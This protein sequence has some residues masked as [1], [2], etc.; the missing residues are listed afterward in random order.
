LLRALRIADSRENFMNTRLVLASALFVACGSAFAAPSATDTD[1]V[2][3]A[4]QAGI[5]EIAAGH[6]AEKQGQ[7]AGTK[8]FGKRMVADH[9]KAAD[10]LKRAAEKSGA[11]MPTTTSEAQKQAGEKLAGLRGDAFDKAYAE[12][13]VKD[14]EEAV[15]LFEKESTSGSDSDLKAFA[16]MTLPTL[17]EH[18]KMARALP[19][20]GAK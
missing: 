15:A 19:G 9:T 17:Q 10:G 8:A 2:T 16:G 1:F 7:S 18:L 3:K 20:G 14:H 11:K 5:A 6:M 13:M 4:G 12:Q